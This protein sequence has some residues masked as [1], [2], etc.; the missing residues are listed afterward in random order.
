MKPHP[1]LEQIPL[2]SVSAPAQRGRSWL[3]EAA[4][5]PFAGEDGFLA[6]VEDES[7]GPAGEGET[8][9][10]W[11]TTSASTY[12]ESVMAIEG[13]AAGSDPLLAAV[14]ME[15]RLMPLAA[16]SLVP[17]T[18][19]DAPTV[20][21]MPEA[22]ETEASLVV[23]EMERPGSDVSPDY[24]ATAFFGTDTGTIT[25]LRERQ[26]KAA[27]L[28]GIASVEDAQ[29]TSATPMI[30]AGEM[31]LRAAGQ[32]AAITDLTGVAEAGDSSASPK[33]A[34][35]ARSGREISA[36][37]ELVTQPSARFPAPVT[38]PQAREELG[39]VPAPVQPSPDYPPV[40]SAAAAKNNPTPTSGGTEPAFFAKAADGKAAK[41]PAS[42]VTSELTAVAHAAERESAGSGIQVRLQES[43]QPAPNLALLMPTT[44]WSMAESRLAAVFADEPPAQ[45]GAIT[46]QAEGTVA[47]AAPAGVLGTGMQAAATQTIGMRDSSLAASPVP[48]PT[49]K[50]DMPLSP[51]VPTP[52]PAVGPPATVAANGTA[53]APVV[54]NPEVDLELHQ[55]SSVPVAM[56]RSGDAEGTRSSP[57]SAPSPRTVAPMAESERNALTALPAEEM[58]FPISGTGDRPA[59]PSLDSLGPQVARPMPGGA[60]LIARQMAEAMPTMPDS[61]V[62]VSLAPE[63]LGKVRLTLHTVE[64]GLSVV[65][66]AERPETLDLMRRNIDSL[67]RDFREMGYASISFDFGSERGQNRSSEPEQAPSPPDEPEPTT[68]HNTTP[69]NLKPLGPTPIGGLDLR[70]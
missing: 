34:E 21:G 47:K 13:F 56:R 9:M 26:P 45:Q 59:T 41:G 27:K 52:G 6:L 50:A 61:P 3:P 64:G 19:I 43:R 69:S 53:V 10:A 38:T 8:A 11:R 35:M 4:Q 70:I 37:Q 49:S 24:R 63:E 39:G 5:A 33:G 16:P 29:T 36:A 23:T 57:S 46:Q 32:K 62:E 12:G 40:N 55:V 67:A 20:T 60:H 7:A 25:A 65:V 68:R 17:A 22:S 66:Q 18:N 14:R 42:A 44:G 54:Q 28:A 1:L 30:N 48:V 58:L 15:S 51:G 31:P 2:L